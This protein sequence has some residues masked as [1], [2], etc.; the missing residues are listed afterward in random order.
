MAFSSNGKSRFCASGDYYVGWYNLQ[1]IGSCLS[2]D[3][4]VLIMP[5]SSLLVVAVLILGRCSWIVEQD[6]R[7]AQANYHGN[8]EFGVEQS[9]W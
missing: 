6:V 1:W 8:I 5:V 9:Q 4:I 3:R 7:V 2:T